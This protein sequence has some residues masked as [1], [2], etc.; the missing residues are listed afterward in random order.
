M[1]LEKDINRIKK[2]AEEKEEEN[3]GFRTFLKSSEIPSKKIDAMVQQLNRDISA[4]IDCST[5]G[6][7]C[8]EMPVK[9]SERDIAGMANGLK[10]PQEAFKK[11]YLEKDEDGETYVFNSKPCPFL[12]GNKCS[13]HSFR[14]DDCRSYPHLHKENFTSRTISVIHNCSVCPIAFN[15]YEALKNEIWAMDEFDEYY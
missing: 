12:D 5:C 9:L 15:V 4:Q 10:M 8:R 3:W 13:V 14:P 6:N 7:C 11:Q 2:L 1:K